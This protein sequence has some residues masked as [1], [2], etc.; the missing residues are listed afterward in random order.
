[1][2]LLH[3]EGKDLGDYVQEFL[4]C[5]LVRKRTESASPAPYS[6]KWVHSVVS[7]PGGQLQVG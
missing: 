6:V 3:N 1:M 7:N 5:S 2:V 4:S